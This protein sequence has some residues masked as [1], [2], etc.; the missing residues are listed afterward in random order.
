MRAPFTLPNSLDM[1]TTPPIDAYHR[2]TN[3]VICAGYL[4]PGKWRQTAHRGADGG[5]F[6]KTSAREVDVIHNGYV[7]GLAC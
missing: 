6:E 2:N 3:V 5:G 4:R 1:T 7:F